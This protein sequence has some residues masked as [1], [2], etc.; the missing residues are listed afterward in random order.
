[1]SF[2]A[3]EGFVRAPEI[4]V[5]KM[6]LTKVRIIDWSLTDVITIFTLVTVH[7]TVRV[8]AC[9]CHVALAGEEISGFVI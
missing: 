1:M 5:A 9:P 4:N 3:E 8:N 7:C 6:T 2:T